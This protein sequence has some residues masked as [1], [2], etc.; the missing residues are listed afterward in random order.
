MPITKDANPSLRYVRTDKD[1]HFTGAINQNATEEENITGLA[2]S[3]III[4]SIAILSDQL[5][6]YRVILFSQDTF[7]NADLDVDSFWGEIGLDL[8][9][10]GFQIAGAG[11]YYMAV[12]GLNI[13]Y[14]DKDGSEELHIALQNLSAT[15]KNAGAT[16][17]VVLEVHYEIKE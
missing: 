14:E 9:S 7:D 3:K 6:N 17:E 2:S 15:A 13:P 4:N 8:P 12:T 11:K 5:L 10:Y 16:G 1:T